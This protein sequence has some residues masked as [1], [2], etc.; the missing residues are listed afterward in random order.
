MLPGA[1]AVH[2]TSAPA[3]PPLRAAGALLL[4]M[5]VSASAAC[6]STAP[7][8]SPLS[9]TIFEDV[10]AP[11][12]A[13][14]RQA[15][16]ESFSHRTP[17]FRCGR[18]SFDWQGPEADAIRFY[19]ERMTAPPYSWTFAGDQGAESGSTRLHFVKG[20]DRCTV[21]IDHIPRPGIDMQDNLAIVVRVNYR[22]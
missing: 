1:V 19:K 14:Y 15:N 3:A 13:T 8:A 16:G 4:A 22:R 5:L 12:G 20:E 21:D 2:A 7:K 18:F 17:T 6:Q 10:L 11:R 9:A